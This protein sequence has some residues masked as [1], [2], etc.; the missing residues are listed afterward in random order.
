MTL[1][2][3]C[4]TASSVS[5]RPSAKTQRHKRAQSCGKPPAAI[6]TIVQHGPGRSCDWTNSA[7]PRFGR[8]Q[9]RRS[10]VRHSISLSVLAAGVLVEPLALFQFA[11]PLKSRSATMVGTLMLV[12]DTNTRTSWSGVP[13][14]AVRGE[15]CSCFSFFQMLVSMMRRPASAWALMLISQGN[16]HP[17]AKL[18]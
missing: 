15:P 10:C 17:Q 13:M 12:L 18:A 11:F 3:S 4:A 7:R 9:I 16:S 8:Q 2:R 1:P 5:T 6:P 14:S